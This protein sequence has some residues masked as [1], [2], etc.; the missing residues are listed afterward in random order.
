[1]ATSSSTGGLRALTLFVALAL[2][3]LVAVGLLMVVVA[4][5]PASAA[6]PGVNSL[7][8]FTSDRVT[9]AN[10]TGDT[11]IYTMD[12]TNPSNTLT[13]LTDNQTADEFPAWSPDGTQIVFVSGR[14]GNYEIYTMDANGDNETNVSNDARFDN[15]P[16]FSADG[17]KI[18]LVRQDNNADT[19]IYKMDTDPAT[20]DAT[21]LTKNSANDLQPAWSP[22]GQ[23]IVFASLRDGDAEIY[24][25]KPNGTD[26]RRLTKNSTIDDA[27]DWSP[28]GK[29]IAYE[30]FRAGYKIFTMRADGSRKKN[31]TNN[32]AQDQFPAFAPDGTQIAFSSTRDGNEEIY[33]MNPDGSNPTRLTNDSRSDFAPDWQPL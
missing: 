23:K 4:A 30:S 11:E 16:A 13:Q 28:S 31:L 29:K 1:M 7:I 6:F 24:T 15:D 20:N 18:V 33:E 12:P 27:P 22:N 3:A 25:M 9:T 10:P 26:L 5:K 19:E 2:A 17:Q 8:A 21:R 32:A 14:D